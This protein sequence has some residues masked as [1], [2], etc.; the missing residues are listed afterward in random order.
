MMKESV[1]RIEVSVKE[2]FADPRSV[3]LKAATE[4]R[5]GVEATDPDSDPL[6]YVWDI[7]PEVE[8]PP[9]SYAGQLEK[10]AKPIEGLIHDHERP[11]VRFTTPGK[12]GPYRLFVTIYDANGSAAYGNIPFFVAER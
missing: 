12:S 11:Q 9:G 8:I 1:Y 4:Y 6:T 5:A 2:G 7:R 10:R 3:Y